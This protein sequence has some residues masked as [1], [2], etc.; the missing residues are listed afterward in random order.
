MIVQNLL[1][2]DGWVEETP[3]VWSKEGLVIK[4]IGSHTNR[5]LKPERIGEVK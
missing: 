2:R 4:V 5:T 3:G 1:T